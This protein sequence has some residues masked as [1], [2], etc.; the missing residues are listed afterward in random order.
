VSRAKRLVVSAGARFGRLVVTNADVGGSGSE[1]RASCEALCQCGT[2]GV[3]IIRNL[4]TGRTRSCGCFRTELRRAVRVEGRAID[5]KVSPE[6]NCWNAIHARCRADGQDHDLYF[7]RGITVCERWGKFE[8]FLADMGRRPSSAYSID[9][10]DNNGNY[11][12][13]NCRWATATQQAR[14]RRSNRWVVLRGERRCFEEWCRIS[15]V[16]SKLADK[17]LKMGWSMEDAIFR[18]V[19]HIKR[20][21][22]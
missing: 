10:I 11:E 21:A 12:P 14:N 20:R 13:G 18:E 3:Y 22:S 8:N 6:Y 16:S 17:R 15:G 7:D 19:R 2:T 9:R 5:R 1:G 4:V